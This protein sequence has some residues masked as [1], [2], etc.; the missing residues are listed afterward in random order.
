MN[1]PIAVATTVVFLCSFS[2]GSL[3]AASGL[4]FEGKVAAMDGRPVAGAE[5]QEVQHLP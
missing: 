3:S 2:M 4:I 1:R 5:V